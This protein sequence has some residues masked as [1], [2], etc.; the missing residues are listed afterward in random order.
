MGKKAKDGQLLIKI[1]K[2][3]KKQFIELCEEED[4]TASQEIRKFIKRYIKEN[5]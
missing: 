5:K 3:M 2:E 1:D 4:T